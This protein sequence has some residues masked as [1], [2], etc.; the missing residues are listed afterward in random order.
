MDRGDVVDAL[1]QLSWH[2]QSRIGDAAAAAGVSLSQL[3]L[4][5]I[6]RDREPEMLE[7]ARFL[8]LDKSSV[9]GLVGRAEIRGLVERM[10][11]P[12]DGRRVAVRLTA[13]GRALAAGLESA[14]EEQLAA[15][16]DAMSDRDQVELVQLVTENVPTLPPSRR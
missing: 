13:S 9:S 12:S 5:G 4:L 1:A 16:I 3:R 10:P 8:Q 2:V 15:L 7:L 11:L 14:V 6:L